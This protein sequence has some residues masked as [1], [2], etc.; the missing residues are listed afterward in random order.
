MRGRSGAMD[1]LALQCVFIEVEYGA[2]IVENPMS[3][4]E[5]LES[6]KGEA[7]GGV[8]IAARLIAQ[9]CEAGADVMAVFF[10]LL[11][12]NICSNRDCSTNGAKA[13]NPEILF[14]K[15][16]RRFRWKWAS[17][18]LTLRLSSSV[19]TLWRDQL[20]RRSQIC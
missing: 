7:Q 11:C 4:F 3:G 9:Q 15:S 5:S 13:M 10:E 14:F 12:F 19:C 18:D 17:K 1:N 16:V 2:V 8:G 20:E 6:E